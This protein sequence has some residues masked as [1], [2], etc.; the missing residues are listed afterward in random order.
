MLIRAIV[1]PGAV[2]E[3]ASDRQQVHVGAQEGRDR[4]RGRGHD[5]LLDVERG[6]QEHRHA[7]R[8]PEGRDQAVVERVVGGRDGVHPRGAVGVVPA[9]DRHR[10]RRRPGYEQRVE[11]VAQP[12]IVQGGPTGG[13]LDRIGTRG[14]G[15]ADD[16]CADERR[17]DERPTNDPCTDERR[18]DERCTNERCTNEQRVTRDDR[19]T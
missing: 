6:V 13:H 3:G 4:L 19:R 8:L 9:G 15:G 18:T 10:D 17:T 12:G 11:A 14:H 7:G 2:G 1:P 16:R 5:R